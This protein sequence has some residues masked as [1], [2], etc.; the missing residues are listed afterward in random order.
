[1][2]QVTIHRRCRG[3]EYRIEIQNRS[4]GEPARLT[5]NGRRIDGGL[6]P[7]AAPGERVEVRVDL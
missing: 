1:M 3:A 6:V 7:H 2:D 5:V 4:T